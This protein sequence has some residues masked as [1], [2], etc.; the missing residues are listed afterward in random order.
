MNITLLRHGQTDYNKS[1]LI[2][3]HKD[4]PLNDEGRRQAL[5]AG[6]YFKEHNISF[7]LI[8]A[9][10]L[11]RALETAKIVANAINYNNEIIIEKDFIERDFGK[12]EGLSVPEW[13]EIIT[14]D[15]FY[16]DNY[17]T[18]VEIKKRVYNA[19]LELENKYS[20]Y[21][22]ILIAC[23][24]HTIK[25]LLSSIDNQYNFQTYLNNASIHQFSLNNQVG[26]IVKFNIA[27]V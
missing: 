20:N 27:V 9:T 25:A 1:K 22:N 4:N 3:G 2:Q 15:D 11:D 13:V 8:I 5:C 21:E 18:N 12:Y 23:H 26:K 17:E 6:N 14:K 19:F 16:D 7:D 24:S 10:P